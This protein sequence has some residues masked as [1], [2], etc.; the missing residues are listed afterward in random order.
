MLLV[1]LEHC[2]LSMISERVPFHYELV[3]GGDL[4]AHWGLHFFIGVGSLSISDATY[5][6]WVDWNSRDVDV[7]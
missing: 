3:W 7:V 2:R 5:G 6:E 1:S 4:V